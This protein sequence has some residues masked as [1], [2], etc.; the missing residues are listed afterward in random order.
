MSADSRRS[1]R[2]TDFLPL[3][4]QVVELQSGHQLAGPFASRIIDISQ[5]GACL[6]MSQVMRNGFHVFHSTQ[7][8]DSCALVLCI[9]LPPNFEYY[10]ILARPIWLDLFQQGEI[11]AFKMGVEFIEDT[12]K[13][14]MKELQKA[15]RINQDRRASWWLS[16][17]QGFHKE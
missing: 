8:R 7:E 17:Y 2:L 3:E 1:P 12:N 13:K 15:L 10:Q 14:E 4:T 16:H 11:R 5:H 9:N 6:L